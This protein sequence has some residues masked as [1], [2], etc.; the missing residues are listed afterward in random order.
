MTLLSRFPITRNLAL[1]AM[2]LLVQSSR[3]R[4]RPVTPPPLA[5]TLLTH[6]AL[7]YQQA[8]YRLSLLTHATQLAPESA[9]GHN[10]RALQLERMGRHAG[11]LISIDAAIALAEASPELHFNRG[12]LLAALNQLEQA[13]ASYT[14]SIE[15]A[16]TD[17]T[18]L[19]ARA[20]IYLTLD[21]VDSARAD[22]D[23]ASQVSPDEPAIQNL[24][25]ELNL[26][27]ARSSQD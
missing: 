7:L 19:C 15:L 25:K 18:A 8:E 16:P 1:A 27:A 5:G 20:A 22:L 21:Q 4:W 10:E 24:I 14:R 17:P 6:D 3:P 11:A 9:R 26:A 12:N 2:L 23:R 13:T